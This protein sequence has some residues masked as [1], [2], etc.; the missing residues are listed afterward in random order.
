MSVFP[1]S[2]GFTYSEAIPYQ[3]GVSRRDPSPVVR[4]GGTYYVWYSRSTSDASGYGATVWYATS[5]DGKR[6]TERSEAVGRGPA[7]AFDE[8]GVFTPTVLVDRT[9]SGESERYFI[10]YTAVREPFDNDNG[11]PKGNPT[12]IGAA[13]A[14]S[15]DGPWERTGAGPVIETSDD[16][17]SFDSHRVDD[18][19]LIRRDGRFLL[20][21]KGRQRGR[22]PA[23]TKMGLAVADRP[24]G[25]FTKY[26]DNPV[27]GSGHEVCVWPHGSGVAALMAPVG[28]DGRSLQYSEDGIRFHKVMEVDP[29]SAPGPYREDRWEEGP[30]PG[31]TWGLCQDVRSRPDWPFL[32]RFDCDLRSG[33]S[34]R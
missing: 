10:Y 26:R 31:I 22:T 23:Q 15:P 3:E 1:F 8:H 20:Y 7:G 11:G 32:L 13:Y 21:Y 27:I 25:P 34:D 17:D 12:A 6:W 29:P 18:A 2:R 16:P 14:D 19:C 4:I 28:P 5:P 24:E 30:G 33:P 9:G